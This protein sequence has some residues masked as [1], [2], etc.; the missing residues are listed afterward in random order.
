MGSTRYTNYVLQVWS[1]LSGRIALDRMIGR[2]LF[3]VI[4]ESMIWSIWDSDSRSMISY[5]ILEDVINIFGNGADPTAKQLDVFVSHSTTHG[6]VKY[7]LD[8]YL[9]ESILPRND[10][11]DFD[12]LYWWKSNG[13]KY[14][15]LDDI[16]RDI[17][18]IHVST[19]ASESCFS[20]S[21]RI[22][23]PHRSQLHSKTVEAL[24]CAR[25]WLW[26]SSSNEN[27]ARRGTV[28]DEEV[29]NNEEEVG[30]LEFYDLKCVVWGWWMNALEVIGWKW[31]VVGRWWGLF[32]KS[33]CGMRW[34]SWAERDGIRGLLEWIDLIGAHEEL[35]RV[36]THPGIAPA[37]NSLNFGVPTNPKPVSSQKASRYED[38]SQHG[39]CF[40]E[41]TKQLPRV[42]THP[43]IAP[44]SNS[45]NFGVPTNPKPVSSQKASCYE[46]ARCA[47]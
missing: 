45:L 8:H 19:V 34:V 11:D 22:I 37:S 26:T 4:F 41:L 27:E 20:T 6:H 40:W 15:T 33:G 2:S 3:Y 42:V 17:L 36:V 21:Q 28:Q 47:I 29:D 12:I 43:G 23:S 38:A 39:F 16:A 35:P 30:V 7:E 32:E 13:I 10:D 1:K 9:E 5:T 31:L 24:M 14:P 44:A 18:A 25:D 46:D